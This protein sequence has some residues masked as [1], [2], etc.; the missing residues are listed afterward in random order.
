MN[1]PFCG[2]PMEEGVLNSGDPIHWSESATGLPVPT[3]R[4]DV[5]LGKMLGLLRPR[6]LLCRSCRKVI[7]DY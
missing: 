7:V 4:G 3:R 6:A 1:C 2:K 5:I